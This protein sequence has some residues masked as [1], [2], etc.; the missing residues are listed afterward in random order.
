MWEGQRGPGDVQV[1]ELQELAG[2]QEDVWGGGRCG[3]LGGAG[4]NSD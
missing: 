1:G 2:G 4:Q 3:D